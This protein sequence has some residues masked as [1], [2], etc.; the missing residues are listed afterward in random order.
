MCFLLLS[1]SDQHVRPACIVALLVTFGLLK[2][3]TLNG[4]VSLRS[5]LGNGNEVDEVERPPNRRGE[6]DNLPLA[7]RSSLTMALLRLAER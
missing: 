2:I 5:F 4:S 3:V 1:D 6:G 7:T